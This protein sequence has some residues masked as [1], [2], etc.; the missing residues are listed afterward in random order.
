M[1]FHSW[2][3]EDHLWSSRLP[4]H[5]ANWISTEILL[6]YWIQIGRTWMR[7]SWDILGGRGQCSFAGHPKTLDL[8][9][10]NMGEHAK[11]TIGGPLSY[12]AV[13]YCQHLMS[14]IEPGVVGSV[15]L[16]CWSI[17]IHVDHYWISMLI[18]NF[19]YFAR[20]DPEHGTS[21]QTSKRPNISIYT[22]YR[23]KHPIG[24]E[25]FGTFGGSSQQLKP[26]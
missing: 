20:L 4:C 5:E 24:H 26:S 9:N 10:N 11:W 21:I 22:S 19:A 17:L 8:D 25:L 14:T 12:L 2:V 6:R 23:S 16:A 7:K 15:L 1:P 3:T 13:R 18:T